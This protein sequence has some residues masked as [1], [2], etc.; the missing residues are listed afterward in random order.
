MSDE[1]QVTQLLRLLA[2]LDVDVETGVMQ[3]GND[4]EFYCD[5]IRELHEDVL[6]RRAAALATGEGAECLQYA[7]LLKGT[8]QTLGE[9]RAS[10]RA[11]ELEQ[12]LRSGR[13]GDE[14]AR[15]LLK[16]LERLD[17]ALGTFFAQ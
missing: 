13:P 2:T 8:L 17:G 14:L 10:Q 16:D 6:V 12:A 3:C 9:T 1:T 11:R 15:Q 7:H 5:L 4:A